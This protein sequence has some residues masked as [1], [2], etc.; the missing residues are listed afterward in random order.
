MAEI[1]ERKP[2][3]ITHTYF[4]KDGVVSRFDTPVYD[5]EH[6]GHGFSVEGP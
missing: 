4:E 2:L 1:Y 3:K 6:L 5:L